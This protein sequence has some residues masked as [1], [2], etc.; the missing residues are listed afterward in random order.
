LIFSVTNEKVFNYVGRSGKPINTSFFERESSVGFND[1]NSDW[2]L[3]FIVNDNR[4]D[5]FSWSSNDGFKSGRDQ[6]GNNMITG[7]FDGSTPIKILEVHD[8]N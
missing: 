5:A 3:R 7:G 2:A 8:I 6:Y 1:N 4:R